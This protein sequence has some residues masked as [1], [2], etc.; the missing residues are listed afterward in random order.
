MNTEI[1]HQNYGRWIL[2]D[3]YGLLEKKK[4][5]EILWLKTNNKEKWEKG[6]GN[7]SVKEEVI[8]H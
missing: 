8:E 1:L 6:Q 5:K 7:R 4:W 2:K 3:C